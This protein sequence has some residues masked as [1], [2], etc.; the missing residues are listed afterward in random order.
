MN[1]LHSNPEEVAALYNVI[2]KDNRPR[3]RCEE[4]VVKDSSAELL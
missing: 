2:K 3:E 1:I 4:E